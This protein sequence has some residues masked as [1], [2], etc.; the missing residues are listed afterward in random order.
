MGEGAIKS[1][2]PIY[3][4]FAPEQSN[5]ITPLHLVK[6]VED[7]LIGLNQTNFNEI[8]ISVRDQINA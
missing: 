4:F 1:R 5:K 3:A 8:G 6:C 2:G 7:D